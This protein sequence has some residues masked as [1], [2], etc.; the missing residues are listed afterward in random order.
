MLTG[1]FHRIKNLDMQLTACVRRAMAEKETDGE[2]DHAPE[3]EDD[4]MAIVNEPPAITEPPAEVSTSVMI[5][6]DG[7]G[8]DSPMTE[9]E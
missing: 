5:Q 3:S 1:V 7:L 4:T 6:D 2:G 8:G 9:V